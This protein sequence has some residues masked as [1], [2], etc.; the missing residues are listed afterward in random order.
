M[1]HAESLDAPESVTLA[2]HNIPSL[3]LSTALEV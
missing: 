2:E 1:Q 3:I